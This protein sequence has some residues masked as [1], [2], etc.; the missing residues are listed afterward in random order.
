M[1]KCGAK[2]EWF[3]SLADD[4]AEIPEEYLDPP[5]L[6]LDLV[7]DWKAFSILSGSRQVGMT[8]PSRI[9]VSEVLSYCD[10]FGILDPG[11]R[12]TLLHRIQILD[13]EFMKYHNE[14]QEQ[15]KK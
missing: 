11:S 7:Y 5:A 12:A 15:G 8:G 2:A 10:L 9:A 1:L 14:Q 6:I 4:G 3:A 13:S